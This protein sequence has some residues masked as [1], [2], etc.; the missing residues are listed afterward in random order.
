[1]K[2]RKQSNTSGTAIILVIS[3]MATLM[4][5]VGVAAEYTSSIHRNVARSNTLGNAIAVADGCIDQSFAYWR[6]ISKTP[7]IQFPAT[8]DLDNIP[9]PTGG[10]TSTQFPAIKNF[11]ATRNDYAANSTTTVQQYKVVAL[12]PQYVQMWD[13]S[14]SPTKQ[15]GQGPDSIIYNY[16]ATAYVTL[17][18]IRGNVVAKV[19]RV[20]QKRQESPWNW[21]IFYN[22]PLEIHPGPEFHVTGWVHTN[23]DLYT[24]HDTLWFDEKV[25][26]GG[27]WSVGFKP[28]DGQHPEKPVT[29]HYTQSPSL[30][31]GHE[32]FDV[33]PS[34]F[35]AADTN[36][37]NDS[38]SE[39]I[40]PPNSSYSDPLSSE[41][42]YNQ[43]GV[44]IEV[45]ASNTII[46]RNS[47]GT[48]LNSSSNGNDKKL[49]DM[50][51][52]AV[53]TN[54]TIQ[55]N[56]E[57]ATMRV[58]TLDVSKLIDWNT[59]TSSG[60]PYETSKFNGVV[61]MYDSSAVDSDS[62][63][64]TPYTGPK[65][66][67]RIKNGSYIPDGGLTVASANPVYVQGDFNTGTTGTNVPSNVVDSYKDPTTTPNPQAS[68]YTRQPCSIVA[69]AVNVLSNSWN[70]ANSAASISSRVASNTTI[71][72]AIVSG[73]VPSGS[74]GNN[75][76]G[77]AENFPRFLEDW[78]DAYL[79]YYGSMVE[80]YKSQ[81]SIGIWGHA[82]VYSPPTREWFFDKNFKRD[83]PPGSP[84]V[85]TYVKGKWAL[86]H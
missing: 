75:Y 32:P 41:R 40:E 19:Q 10:A 2:I 60:H 86:A 15:M 47:S 18:A 14:L 45:N 61:Y 59:W 57:Q 31:T 30:D 66:A 72:A 78:S 85:F 29:P 27:D 21:A 28:G 73:I 79:T 70:D 82:N 84:L 42:Y 77:G 74:S 22:D 63:P 55:D 76:S 5:I 12:N 24:G 69:D 46:L 6:Q 62:N 48:V 43:A 58:A 23:S 36:P 51:K 34:V 17:P 67:I 7:G 33:S 56:R 20:F 64:N 3:I 65:R 9:L 4:V 49:Y 68:W 52:D 38:Y 13:D 35:N 25:T 83:T 50:F 37:N 39:L 54:E 1:M 53:T 11:A 16:L 44:T 26:Y 71:N 80:L 81:Q 8:D